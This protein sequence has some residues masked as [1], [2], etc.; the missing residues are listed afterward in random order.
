MKVQDMYSDTV[1]VMSTEELINFGLGNDDGM[2]EELTAKVHRLTEL[3]ALLLDRSG[4]SDEEILK[5]TNCKV[6][7]RTITRGSK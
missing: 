1:Q 7:F 3:V 4:M 5:V 2:L 6:W